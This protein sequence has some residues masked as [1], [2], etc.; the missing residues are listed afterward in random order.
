[1][2]TETT[3]RCQC[4]LTGGGMLGLPFLCSSQTTPRTMLVT[5]KKVID[6]LPFTKFNRQG[7]SPREQLPYIHCSQSL[8]LRVFRWKSERT[9]FV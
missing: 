6:V 3:A 5:E 9:G 2:Q 1:M 4:I 7:H 8:A